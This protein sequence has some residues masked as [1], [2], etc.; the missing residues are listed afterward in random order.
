DIQTW[1]EVCGIKELFDVEPNNL[2]DDRIA[3]CL[4]DLSQ[5]FEEIQ[6][7]LVMK[8]IQEFNL[9]PEEI[10]WD[11]TSIYFEGDYDEAEI[12]QFGYG[13]KPDLKQI[14][15]ALNVEKD[16]GVPLRGS[17]IKGNLNDPSIVVENMKK[18]RNHLNKKDLLFTGDNAVGT[19]PNCLLLNKNNIKFIAPSPASSLFEEAIRSVTDEELDGCIFPDKDG[20]PKFK[21]TERGVYIHLQDKKK[22]QE[23]K[24]APE[25]WARCLIVWSKSRAKLDREKREKYMSDIKERLEDIATTKLNMRRYK[26]KEYAQKQ[27]D[28]CFQGPKSYLRPIFGNPTVE[29]KGGQLQLVY[30]IDKQLLAEIE[31]QDGLYPVVTNVY[32]YEKY[33]TMELFLRTRKKYSVEQPMRY[34]KSKIKVRP[35]F[36]H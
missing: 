31:K 12:V 20:T 22:Q 28:N 7:K 16:S 32:D 8:I 21:V 27:V 24:D 5:Y 26:N 19:I 6:T 25:F 11:T 15:L 29:E 9:N 2:N 13:D 36:L 1:A 18:L 14:K 17:V 35:I 34:L 33:S 3:R 4:E 23:L 30:S 10:L